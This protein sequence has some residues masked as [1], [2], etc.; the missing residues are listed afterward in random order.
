M[1]RH[2]RLVAALCAAG[3]WA[4][5]LSPNQTAAQAP[6]ATPLVT[7]RA[8]Y[9]QAQ[10]AAQKQ[11][12]PTALRLL[13]QAV[14]LG[15]VS[16]ADLQYDADLTA[17]QKQPGWSN[18]LAQAR[19]KQQQHE[20]RFNQPLVALLRKIDQQDQKYRV[21]AKRAERQFGPDSPQVKAAMRKQGMIDVRLIR[22]V[23]SLLARH[24]Y[25]GKSLV[26]EYLKTTA[27]LVIQ[28]TPDEKYLPLLTVAAEKD[29]LP[30]S[31]LAL[32]I[33]RIRDMRG[34]K[35][36]YGSQL[37]PAV[38]GKYQVVPIEDEPNVNI[39]RAKS[40]L[41]PLE[42]YLKQF[43]ITYQV[44]TATHNPNPPELY[45]APRAAAK[46]EKSEVELIGGYEA[47]YARLQYPAAAR[48]KQIT[49]QVTLQFLIDK[50]GKPQDVAVVKGLGYGCDEE[51]LRVMRTARYINSAGQDHEIRVN[52]PFPYVT[53]KA[54]E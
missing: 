2:Y 22:Q 28:H 26:G 9:Q 14:K 7:A 16:A 20:A 50:D 21:E 6:S 34:E 3:L 18:L 37:G 13:E 17:L 30:W 10:A 52:L 41:E 53:G 29:E 35:Q 49:G 5:V 38:Q 19:T 32:F 48:Q 8:A 15:Y 46:E 47:L 40:G 31:S 43:G 11:E 33:D 25:P 12:Y 42:Q 45:V 54:A 39:R 36:L 51:A 44:P 24:G 23:D 4:S 27:F 1:S